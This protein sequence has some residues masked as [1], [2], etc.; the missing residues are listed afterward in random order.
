MLLYQ[1]SFSMALFPT[2]NSNS[3]SKSGR[4]KTGA[5]TNLSP[6]FLKLCSPSNVHTTKL[7][8]SWVKK[9]HKG[10]VK[11]KKSLIH[12][13][14]YPANPK[15][16]HYSFFV[17]GN[18]TCKIHCT[19]SGSIHFNPP[20]KMCLEYLTFFST[21]RIKNLKMYFESSRYSVNNKTD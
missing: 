18:G 11:P 20:V 1:N 21:I 13:L 16:C 6:N 8:L 14:Q 17:W 7:G 19:L 5:L 15:N 2:Y 4:A 9:S 12:V 3:F 10:L